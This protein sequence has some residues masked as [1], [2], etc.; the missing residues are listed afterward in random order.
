MEK[1]YDFLSNSHRI[2]QSGA[3]LRVTGDRRI[4][5]M[6]ALVGLNAAQPEMLAGLVEVI[7]TDGEQLRFFEVSQF[8]PP[9]MKAL[10]DI[11]QFL[12]DNGYEAASKFLDCSFEL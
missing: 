8:R 1:F 7:P 3:I 11:S 9:Y 2:E 4:P 5:L 12:Q 6:D 10:D